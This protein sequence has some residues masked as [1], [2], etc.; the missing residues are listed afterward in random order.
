MRLNVS[1]SAWINNSYTHFSWW[2]VSSNW[3]QPEGAGDRLIKRLSVLSSFFRIR[4]TV[5]TKCFLYNLLWRLGLLLWHLIALVLSAIESF[6]SARFAFPRAFA[7]NS[8]IPHFTVWFV[9][10]CIVLSVSLR[11]RDMYNTFI[12]SGHCL[13]SCFL[14]SG[15]DISSIA[16]SYSHRR[17]NLSNMNESLPSS[18][19]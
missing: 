9:S 16:T 4:W 6:I 17:H 12:K 11:H 19:I 1:S 10:T 3:S 5:F 2:F 15:V 8:C 13:H 18:H 7:F 14:P